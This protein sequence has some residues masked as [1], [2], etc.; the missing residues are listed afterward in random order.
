MGV[1]RNPH[2][3]HKSPK[4]TRSYHVKPKGLSLPDVEVVRVPKPELAKPETVWDTIFWPLVSGALT[5]ASLS[6]II[7][8][9]SQC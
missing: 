5:G 6:L 7:G 9:L 1:S 8:I 4:N 2:V 3:K